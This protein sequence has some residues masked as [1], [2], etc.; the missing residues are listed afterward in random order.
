[1]PLPL[2]D[3]AGILAAALA[4]GLAVIGI[5]LLPGGHAAP[6]AGARMLILGAAF[7]AVAWRLDMLGLAG[8]IRRRLAA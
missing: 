7:V 5:G 8:A 4:A 1:M 6:R 2:P 3:M